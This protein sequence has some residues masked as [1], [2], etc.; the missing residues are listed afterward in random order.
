MKDDLIIAF[1]IWGEVLGLIL[2]ALVTLWDIFIS[3]A[4]GFMQ[5]SICWKGII[6]IWLG[7]GLV[8]ASKHTKRWL[9]D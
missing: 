4:R 8:V 9:N 5:Y 2:I 6:L 7:I 1:G 3:G